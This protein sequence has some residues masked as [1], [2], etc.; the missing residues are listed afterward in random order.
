VTELASGLLTWF[1]KHGRKNLPWQS[2]P[3]NGYHVWL[4]EVMLQQT[5]VKTVIDYFNCFIKRFP[6]I[7]SLAS[8]SEDDVLAAWAGLGYYTRARNLHKTAQRI[9]S[10]YG[11]IFPKT[12]PEIEA[13]PG[14]GRST[15]GAI[16]SLTF[17]L[18]HAILDGNVKR[19]LARYH[20]VAGHYSSSS[21]LNE[22]WRLA[23]K[24]TPKKQNAEYTQAIMDVGAT[25]CTPRS[26]DC[27]RCPISKNC[28]AFIYNQQ[29]DY[30]NKKT[31][32]IKPERSV[33]FLIY[34]NEKGEVHL[35]KRP[36]KG[37][38]GGLWSFIECADNELEIEE[39]I[40]SHNPN[41][42]ILESL[43]TFKHSFSH[44]TLWI[45][46]IIVSSPGC[47]TDYYKIN[48]ISVGMPAPVKKIIQS[49]DLI[50]HA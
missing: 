5:Q 34:K 49:L 17:N 14:V 38:W 24:H 12:Y 37:I 30:P 22:L 1:I 50:N 26:P 35:K 25:V 16:L 10:L 21:V 31:K 3:P 44:F 20:R 42:K 13:L 19:V 9:S 41:A 33:V 43:E 2:S 48:D 39:K 11:G 23:E 46:P 45:S 15:A 32:K 36:N 29:N 27:K 47:S 4:S 40:I 18:P 7:A 8:A 6:D 28:G